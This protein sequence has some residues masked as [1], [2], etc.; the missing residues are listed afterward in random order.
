MTIAH[1]AYRALALSVVSLITATASADVFTLTF[2][3]LGDNAVVGN[4]Y[5][6][7]AGGSYGVEFVGAK[8]LIA[9][10][11]GGTGN[12]TNAPTMPTIMYFPSASSAVMNVADGFQSGFSTYYSSVNFAG[13]VSLYSGLDGTG[14][15]LATLNLVAL[16]TDNTPDADFDRWALVGATFVGTAKSVVFGGDANQIGFDNVTFGS[17]V[18][19]PGAVALL[20]LAGAARGRRRR[21]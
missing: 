9:W 19:A 6:D 7:G 4:Y 8:A 11:V 13:S 17:S 21:A 14:D 16:G 2:E 18:P 12:F 5:N 3:G 15:I 1:L 20:G 10:S